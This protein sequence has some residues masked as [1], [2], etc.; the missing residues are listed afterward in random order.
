M[1]SSSSWGEAH[2]TPAGRE[3]QCFWTDWEVAADGRVIVIRAAE[4]DCDGQLMDNPL[5]GLF[6]A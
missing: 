5:A 1:S 6:R 3:C 4:A 2:V